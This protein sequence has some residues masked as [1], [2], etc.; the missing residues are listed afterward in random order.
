MNSIKTVTLL[1][2]SVM[3]ASCSYIAPSSYVQNR[4]KAF[5]KAKSV[6]PLRIPPGIASSAFQNNYPVSSRQYPYS[7]TSIGTVPPGLMDK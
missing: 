6:P 3:L 5:L 2:V 7:E 4:D 1:L